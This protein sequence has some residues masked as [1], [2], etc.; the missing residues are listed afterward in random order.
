MKNSKGVST[1]CVVLCFLFLL[2]L[3]LINPLVIKTIVGDLHFY[4]VNNI[5]TVQLYIVLLSLS[6]GI[7]GILGYKK[8]LFEFTNRKEKT[9][10]LVVFFIFFFASL[11]Y[12]E[13][14]LRIKPELTTQQLYDSSIPYENSMFARSKL[15]QK[16]TEIYYPYLKNKK[17]HQFNQGYRGPSFP[18]KKPEDEIRIVVM[19]GS[20]IFGDQTPISW[21]NIENEY[22]G[23]WIRNCEEK[24]KQKGFINIRLINAGIPGHTTFDSFGRLYSEVHLFNPDYIILCHGWNDIEYFSEVTPENSLFRQMNP[25]RV[26]TRKEISDILEVSQIYL[27]IKRYFQFE[28]LGVEGVKHQPKK[29]LKISPYAI[30]Q[31]NLNIDLFIQNCKL[32]GAQPILLTQPRLINMNNSMS[33]RKKILY[34]FQ[35]L[36]HDKICEAYQI[37]DSIIIN[38]PQ[39]DTSVISHHFAEKFIGVDSLYVDHLHLNSTGNNVI[40]TSLA[41]YLEKVVVKNPKTS[42]N[43]QD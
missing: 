25:S 6:L 39:K 37:I 36:G 27:R 29:G 18:Y 34:S 15:P 1:I 4:Y 16:F 43:P 30:K 8:N 19:G 7:L 9:G 11:F 28:G 26:Q 38:Y 32:I 21:S 40:S 2:S 41:S 35:R 10:N 13:F 17:S 3:A 23:N 22:N 14:I 20:F 42:Y 31:F 5:H 33:E 24:L 12:I